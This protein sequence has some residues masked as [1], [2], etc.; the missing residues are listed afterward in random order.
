MQASRSLRSHQPRA[1]LRHTPYLRATQTLRLRCRVCAVRT[2]AVGA[3][4]E[5]ARHPST[6]PHQ[7]K[8]RKPQPMPY[9]HQ[10]MGNVL[11]ALIGALEFEDGRFLERLRF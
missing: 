10:K 7:S 4:T 11:L 8:S 1:W 2:H 3:L 9:N 5:S 6:S